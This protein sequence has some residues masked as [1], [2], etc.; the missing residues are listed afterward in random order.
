ME[1]DSDDGSISTNALDEIHYGIY[2]HPYVKGRYSILKILDNIKQAQIECKV[3][4]I[5]EKSM[6][7]GSHKLFKDILS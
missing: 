5:P 7:K 2:L 3:A 1:N 6:G 4:E